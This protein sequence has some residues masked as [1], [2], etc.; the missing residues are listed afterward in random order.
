[1][2]SKSSKI[3]IRTGFNLLIRLLEIGLGIILIFPAL[4][5]VLF[6]T[7]IIQY[8]PD[9]NYDYE[10]NFLIYLDMLGKTWTGDVEFGPGFVSEIPIF[11]GLM[12]IAGAYLIKGGFTNFKINSNDLT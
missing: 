11:F 4:R 5:G 9:N 7:G 8:N 1:M 10:Q 6:L 12:A 2:E 3:L